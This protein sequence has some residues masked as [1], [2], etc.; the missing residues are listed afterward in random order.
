M[1]INN[2]DDTKALRLAAADILY[3]RKITDI[4]GRIIDALAGRIKCETAAER[5]ELVPKLWKEF[6]NAS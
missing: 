1:D 2:N 5:K 4:Q 6:E 3:L